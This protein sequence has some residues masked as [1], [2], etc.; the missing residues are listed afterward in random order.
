[1]NW[2]DPYTFLLTTLG[3]SVILLS[4]ALLRPPRKLSRTL[5]SIASGLAG[6]FIILTV[7][8]LLINDPNIMLNLRNVQQ[9]SLVFTPLFL[10]GYAKEL[11]H[12]S[13]KKTIRF[14]SILAIPSI[15]D[16]LLVFTDSFHGLMR[17]SVTINT[18]WGYTEVST[19][20]THLNSFLGVYPIVI[21]VLTVFLLLRNM[22]DVPKYYRMTHWLSALVIALPIIVIT[23]T[24]LMSIEIPGIFALSICSIVLLLILVNKKID[25]NEVWPV[26]RQEVIE[27]LSEG[28]ILIDQQGKIVEVNRASCQMIE[29]LFDIDDCQTQVINHSVHS[30][31]RE[32]TTLIDILNTK[33]EATFQY[34]RDGFYFDVNLKKLSKKS[35]NLRLVVWKDVTDKKKF[36]LQLKEL[37]EKD[38]LTKLTNRRA[39]IKSYDQNVDIHESCFMLMDI[40]HFKK[41]NDQFGHLV[42][43]RVLKSVAQLLK[44]HFREGLITRLGGEEFGVFLKINVDQAIHR[45]EAFQSAL[46]EESHNIDPAIKDEVTVSIG[47][48]DVKPG[49]HFEN[50]YQQADQLM[51]RAKHEGRDRICV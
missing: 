32:V 40:D 49:T 38:S 19:Q 41:I 14:L 31:F 7:F 42:G 34:E 13:P 4:S 24:S 21:L 9:I 30:I 23:T 39:F 37:A 11:H 2:I 8:E 27:N 18:I 47:I 51:Y 46:K 22:F 44:T 28:I 17:E 43:D 25:F 26:S 33:H 5:L 20:S 48:S 10:L 16:I 3:L 35:N 45:A 36:E 6:V 15:I 12:E 50:V 1:M 29:R